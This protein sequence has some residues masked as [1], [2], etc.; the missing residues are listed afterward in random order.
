MASSA[1]RTAIHLSSTVASAAAARPSASVCLNTGDAL[2]AAIAADGYAPIT[3]DL[4]PADRMLYLTAMGKSLFFDIIPRLEDTERERLRTSIAFRGLYQFF[5]LTGK[6]GRPSPVD[7]FSFGKETNDPVALRAPYFASN[8]FEPEEYRH[9]IERRNPTDALRSLTSSSSSSFSS[10][11][12]EEC[13]DAL[14][15]AFEDLQKVSLDTLQY[16]AA[17]M[18]I[19]PSEDI[20][21]PSPDAAVDDRYFAPYHSNSDNDLVLRLHRA[22]V[23]RLAIVDVSIRSDQKQGSAH[24]A[25]RVLR[26]KTAVGAANPL[27]NLRSEVAADETDRGNA[28]GGDNSGGGLFAVSHFDEQLLKGRPSKEMPPI[29]DVDYST[30]SLLLPDLSGFGLS[31]SSSASPSSFSSSASSSSA[32][33]RSVPTAFEIYCEETSTFEPLILPLGFSSSTRPTSIP[34]AVAPGLFLEKWTDGIIGAT[35]YRERAAGDTHNA[36]IYNGIDA[37]PSAGGQAAVVGG[38]SAHAAVVSSS[39]AAGGGSSAVAFGTQ[40]ARDRCNIAYR[41]VPNF[42]ATIDPFTADE[43]YDPNNRGGAAFVVGD[44]IPHEGM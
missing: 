11:S 20:V 14:L 7:C 35:R 42:D 15:G 39:A 10:S 40:T 30:I 22:V 1:A 6:G 3:H 32:V 44:I 37:S 23:E 33:T 41:C 34:M 28:T 19:R 38:A 16:M 4:F 29:P 21:R 18:G 25:P 26:R 8:G 43:S 5:P 31:T 17:S 36:H 2:L 9:R 12:S 13:V 24:T 27:A